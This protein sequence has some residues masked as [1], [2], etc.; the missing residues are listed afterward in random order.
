MAVS[1]N[2]ADQHRGARGPLT[3]KDSQE[4]C[5]SARQEMGFQDKSRQTRRKLLSRLNYCRMRWCSLRE[6][7]LAARRCLYSWVFY[8]QR[9][10]WSKKT[11]TWWIGAQIR[12]TA[13][14]HPSDKATEFTFE[15]PGRFPT[16]ALR[17]LLLMKI[18]HQS[19]KAW[20]LCL[21]KRFIVQFL[22]A[23]TY[24]FETENIT[25]DSK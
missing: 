23:Y 1:R 12:I 8:T 3:N 19:I 5:D 6:V 4:F 14:G 13:E 22:T 20:N 18:Q 17:N 15:L 24:T 2:W 9:K 10:Y 25:L 21:L 16:V 7:S 11:K